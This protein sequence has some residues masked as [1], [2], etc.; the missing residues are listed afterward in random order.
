MAKQEVSQ[1]DS[2]SNT[3]ISD[4]ASSLDPAGS[5]IQT[6]IGRAVVIVEPGAL[7]FVVEIVVVV[8]FVVVVLTLS[9]SS[10][11][12]AYCKEDEDLFRKNMIMLSRTGDEGACY[13]HTIR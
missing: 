7:A 2:V 11:R 4:E 5:G 3:K 8:N 13:P 9:R 1:S 6:F 10:R 12:G